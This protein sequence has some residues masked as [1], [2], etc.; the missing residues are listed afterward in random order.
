LGIPLGCGDEFSCVHVFVLIPCDENH[1]GIEGCD[2]SLVD[3]A[4]AAR[5]NPA[6]VAQQPT[7][8]SPRTL[9][10][11]GRRGLPFRP[12]Q[13]GVHTS[14]STRSLSS[15]LS[16]TDSAA[17]NRQVVSLSGT[18]VTKCTVQGHPCGPIPCCPGLVCMYRGGSTRAGYACYLKG[19][20][21][22]TRTV[23][24]WEGMNANKLDE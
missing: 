16:V 22:T 5:E 7:T 11:S 1:P 3:G 21:N 4:A 10:P 9:R 24:L 18:G 14:G 6:P 23:S 19:S 13:I 20:V 17:V 15:T 12:R 2:Y 8:T